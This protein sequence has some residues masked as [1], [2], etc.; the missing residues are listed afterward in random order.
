MGSATY[1]L[2]EIYFKIFLI[3]TSSRQAILAQLGLYI[4]TLLKENKVE[5]Q[6]IQYFVSYDYWYSSH[7]SNHLAL[8]I[9]LPAHLH[10]P[11]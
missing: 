7:Y 6:E 8:I 5:D 9:A 10:V 3:S 1:I 2:K 4:S 11:G